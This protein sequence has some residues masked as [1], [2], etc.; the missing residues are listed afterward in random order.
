VKIH[1]VQPGETI[2]SV[3]ERYGISV[4]KLL[5]ANGLNESDTLEEGMKV[6]IPTGRVPVAQQKPVAEPAAEPPKQMSELPKPKPQRPKKEHKPP[7]KEHKPPKM[8]HPCPSSSTWSSPDGS[9][10]SPRWESP[11]Y[12]E[13]PRRY[14]YPM[15]EERYPNPGYP[16]PEVPRCPEHHR[17]GRPEH[18]RPMIPP[19]PQAPVYPWHPCY[20]PCPPYPMMPMPYMMVPAPYMY[21]PAYPPM[22]FAGG[23]MGSESLWCDSADSSW[24]DSVGTRE[25]DD[26]SSSTDMWDSQEN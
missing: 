17:P 8:E 2:E 14:P 20:Y 4:E 21:P 22:M 13:T 3:A 19:M 6:R 7:K 10:R 24:E 26:G 5:Q 15:S 18:C 1:I 11:E 12:W 16:C 23:E 9:P 25:V